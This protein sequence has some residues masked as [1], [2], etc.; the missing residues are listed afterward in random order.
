MKTFKLLDT[1]LQDG[2]YVTQ[3][4][5]ARPSYYKQFGLL[6][7][8]GVDFGHTNKKIKVRSPLSG[9][10]FVGKDPAY[11]DYC[12]I[13]DYT[14]GCAVYIC[15]MTKI[16]VVS[17]QQIKAGQAVGEMHNTGNSDGE[18]VHKNFIILNSSGSNKYR[19]KEYNQG[20]LDPQY[21]R[22]T[23]KP[24]TFP[25][26]EEY[27]ISWV[28]SITGESPKEPMSK[29]LEVCLTDRTKFMDQL[30]RIERGEDAHYLSVKES[31]KKIVSATEE[32]RTTIKSK[33][34]DLDKI[35]DELTKY[36]KKAG[37]FDD[38]VEKLKIV[39]NDGDVS[40]DTVFRSVTAQ[41]SSKDTKIADLETKLEEALKPKGV[42]V[43]K[44][45]LIAGVVTALIA[46]VSKV[47]AE[48]YG[49]NISAE[50]LLAIVLPTLAYI[51]IEGAKDFKLAANGEDTNK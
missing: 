33:E 18:H 50:E 4:Y 23:G 1:F 17:G 48:K 35:T 38:V 40:A 9:T 10:V 42:L 49:I 46:I 16:S 21:P 30:G 5:M 12:V 13:E 31:N 44:R 47:L 43:G 25:G 36:K 41:I 8:E 6:G 22:D 7:H 39:K 26:V 3:N 45:K 14:Q 37:W 28:T 27:K 20:F 11:G 15:H 19:K 24:V 29:E 34:K 32:L 51:G 2:F